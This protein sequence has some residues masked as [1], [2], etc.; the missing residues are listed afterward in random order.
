MPN[1]PKHF[2]DGDEIRICPAC[3]SKQP[4]S[5]CMLGTRGTLIQFQCRYCGWEW[6]E[7]S[8]EDSVADDLASH[9]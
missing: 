9:R 6:I 8:S 7:G 5:E 4:K 2:D 3:G 1:H